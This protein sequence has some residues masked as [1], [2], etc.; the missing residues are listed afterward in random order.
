[1]R[2]TLLTVGGF[3]SIAFVVFHLLFWKIFRWKEDLVHLTRTNSGIMQVMN[4]RLIYI[5]LV[6]GILSFFYQDALL[7]T[8]I[9]RFILGAISLF[10]L[11]RGIEQVIFFGLNNSMSIGLFV[12][13]LLGGGLYLAP[14]L[15]Q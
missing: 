15:I 4:L 6:F 2:T 3:Y 1:M 14:I 10:W 11:A 12:I 9:G 8:D 13:F 7:S 5:F